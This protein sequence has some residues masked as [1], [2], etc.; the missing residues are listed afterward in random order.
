MID[1]LEKI[2]RYYNLTFNFD[3]DV[4][5]QN[6]TCSGKIYLSENLDNVMTTIALLTSTE[7]RKEN[8]NIYITNENNNK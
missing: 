4:N 5:L 7:Y 3:R 2:E 6:R 1:V 8:N